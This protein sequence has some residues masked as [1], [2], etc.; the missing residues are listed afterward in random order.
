M[1]GY[2]NTSVA[3]VLTGTMSD[4][5]FLPPPGGFGEG[6]D[7]FAGYGGNDALSGGLGADTL[8]GGLGDDRLFGG[9]GDDRLYGGDGIDDFFGGSGND[10][11]F[12]GAGDF[13]RMTFDSAVTMTI[14]AGTTTV[15]SG[16]Y[17]ITFSGIERYTLSDFANSVTGSAENETLTGG[18]ANDTL[19]GMAGNDYLFLGNGRDWAF[20]GDGNDH[21]VGLTTTGN[22]RVYGE[23]GNDTVFMGD[24]RDTAYG[25]SGNDIMIQ[26]TDGM[27]PDLFFGGIGDD[28]LQSGGGNDSLYGG[29]GNDTV[30]LT[31]TDSLTIDLRLTTQTVIVNGFAVFLDSFENADMDAAVTH[32]TG[33]ADANDLQ[34]KFGD[35]VVIALGGNDTLG[36]GN[37]ADRMY[38]GRGND[39]MDQISSFGALGLRTEKD[40]QADTLTGG[41]GADTFRFLNAVSSPYGA[42]RADTITD[43]TRG[44]DKIDLSQFYDVNRLVNAQVDFTFIGRSTFSQDRHELRFAGG[45]LQGDVNGD[46]TADF[47]VKLTGVTTLTTADLIL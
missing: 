17:Q 33:N 41:D 11:L 26:G 36:F 34:T 14:L 47:A 38:G 6:R 45:V 10:A 46:G 22:K 39:F 19:R 27:G 32:V 24:G 43:F 8:Y 25:G 5:D 3:D 40:A 1:A 2:L 13:D 44:T 29:T 7:S 21:L 23:Q 4:D 28:F 31:A 30:S 12:G 16:G 18:A 42:M 37:G 15:T 20:G 35:D 9:D